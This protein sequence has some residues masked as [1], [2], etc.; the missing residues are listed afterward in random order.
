MNTLKYLSIGLAIA[1]LTGCHAMIG[2]P[3]GIREMSRWH[4]GLITQG[5]SQPQPNTPTA[6]WRN[7]AEVTKGWS[8]YGEKWQEG[9]K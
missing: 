6:F 4:N 3:S 1:S 2:S 7:E 5:K 8:T 9:V